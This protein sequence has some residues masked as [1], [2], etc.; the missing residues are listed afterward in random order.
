MVKNLFFLNQPLEQIF[1]DYYH[2][3]H[4]GLKGFL[5][6]FFSSTS[7]QKKIYSMKAFAHAAC[8][9]KWF[10]CSV[11]HTT[12]SVSS[13]LEFQEIGKAVVRFA[14]VLPSLSHY[15]NVVRSSYLH[16]YMERLKVEV[17]KKSRKS[18]FCLKSITVQSHYFSE[19]ISA[20][21]SRSQ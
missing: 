15:K 12:C 3:G 1:I 8:F 10:S 6:L 7:E 18:A 2:P 9:N 16:M 21:L 20:D 5:V 11:T 17:V 13:L 4:T 14:W 19:Q